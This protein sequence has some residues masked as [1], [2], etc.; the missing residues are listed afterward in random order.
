MARIL[1]ADDSRTILKLISHFLLE[2]GYEVVTASDGREAYTIFKSEMGKF[3]LIITD[4]NMPNMN[5]IELAQKIRSSEFNSNL[6][7][8]V[9]SSEE[10][11]QIKLKGRDAGVSAWIIK[12]PQKHVL[13]KAVKHFI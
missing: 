2:D 5:G 11:E 9:L 3:D 4:I 6:P 13:I 12:P 10:S 8:I 1:L 7:I